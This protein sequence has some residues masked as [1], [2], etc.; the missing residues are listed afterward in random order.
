M[1]WCW[2][3]HTAATIPEAIVQE[4][5]QRGSACVVDATA[6]AVSKVRR[7]PDFSS[8]SW[9]KRAPMTGV[10]IT[11]PLA[12]R[13]RPERSQFL[14][15]VQYG[16][17]VHSH[18]RS[19]EKGGTI[20]YSFAVLTGS[21]SYLPSRTT[22]PTVRPNPRGIRSRGVK[23]L[24]TQNFNRLAKSISSILVPPLRS[25]DM[26]INKLW[27]VSSVQPDGSNTAL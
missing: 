7:Y 2:W 17:L 6:V 22:P 25:Q 4:T 23:P 1:W 11:A 9:Y 24:Q 13:L 16:E 15:K 18:F 3:L 27:S 10:R 21:A 20:A 8:L 12:A 26:N 14:E 5:R 19:K